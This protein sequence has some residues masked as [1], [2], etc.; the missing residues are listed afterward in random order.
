VTQPPRL[1]RR[2]AQAPTA[3]RNAF[4]EKRPVDYRKFKSHNAEA[5]PFWGRRGEWLGGEHGNHLGDDAHGGKNEDVDLGVAKDP[6]EVLPEQGLAGWPPASGMKKTVPKNRSNNKRIMPTVSAGK[7]RSTRNCVIS[8]IQ[9]K[10]GMRIRVM[11]GARMLMMVTTKLRA[12]KMDDT[13]SI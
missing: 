10:T 1:G 5:H 4:V 8:T 11:P 2:P 6:E 9:T 13:P 3:Q 12:P 7:A